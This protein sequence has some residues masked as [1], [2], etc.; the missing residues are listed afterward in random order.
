MKKSL[1]NLKNLF[2]ANFIAI[3]LLTLFIGNESALGQAVDPGRG[4]YV[5][6]FFAL[7]PTTSLPVDEFS[8]LCS[9]GQVGLN[10]NRE[11]EL[12]TYCKKFHYTYIVLYDL[13]TIFN[14]QNVSINGT[15]L[16]DHLKRFIELGRTSYG[17]VDIGANIGGADNSDDVI[18]YNALR[19]SSSISSIAPYFTNSQSVSSDPVVVG[20]K[21]FI[22]Q[23]LTRNHE[24][25]PV[26]QATKLILQ[27]QAFS[28]PQ[29]QRINFLSIEYE[30]WNPN[31]TSFVYGRFQ[32]ITNRVHD[33]KTIANYTLKSE[34]Y[35]AK[36]I[37][38]NPQGTTVPDIDIANFIDGK[39]ANLVL[40][41]NR[42]ML[43]YYTNTPVGSYNAHNLNRL[44][45]LDASLSTT[46]SATE[47][48]P[49]FSTYLPSGDP[50][51][52]K[53]IN[54]NAK[55]NI[56]LAEREYYEDCYSSVPLSN[57]FYTCHN[58]WYRSLEQAFSTKPPSAT[59][60]NPNT[61]IAKEY[62]LIYVD[63]PI[64][65]FNTG[66]KP[67]FTYSG[68]CESGIMV[69]AYAVHTDGTVKNIYGSVS[70]FIPT[71][72]LTNAN[73]Y[74][75]LPDFIPAINMDVGEYTIHAELSYDGGATIA[76]TAPL[77][78]LQIVNSVNALIPQLTN[79]I[80]VTEFC[81]GAP[82]IFRAPN[83][84][85]N[86]YLNGSLV[87]SAQREFATT[88]SASA[89][90]GSSQSLTYSFTTSTNATCPAGTSLGLNLTVFKNPAIPSISTI[91][92]N[93]NC[94]NTAELGFAAG[95]NGCTYTWST[96]S[97][98]NSITVSKNQLYRVLQVTAEGCRRL[99][100]ERATFNYGCDN[101]DLNLCTTTI[102]PTSPTIQNFTGSTIS[103]QS[104]YTF[105]ILPSATTVLTGVTISGALN[106][107]LIV[108]NGSILKLYGCTL[109]SCGNSW[110]GIY[111]KRWWKN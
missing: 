58:M 34:I 42:I 72:N 12:L 76:Y 74:K 111:G 69:R 62:D 80:G 41:Y 16:I 79:V 2:I 1:T 96:G 99:D 66:A 18:F 39:D 90:G 30:F 6:N 15:L 91:S 51:F 75:A 67:V 3:F 56:F 9:G 25:F 13:G 45:L 87:A 100:S 97:I 83:S 29:N 23:P 20:L 22:E 71:V 7:N 38:A 86:W 81:E 77:K 21:S 46:N 109:S 19:S 17:I 88:A 27:I 89:T 43:T 24:D 59:I 4:L 92:N 52:G 11:I 102:F 64:C 32:Q 33:V 44:G 106:T 84:T 40:N 53:W 101:S 48:Y 10:Y 104:N 37:D 78:Y 65:T 63:G 35:L 26:Q 61:S 82:L 5:N 49:L 108:P 31:N 28:V 55:A 107:Q 95:N 60:P 14:N 85:A 73:T 47:I 93:S 105:P 94:D 68:P 98:G 50:N 70:S 8:I 54:E 110:G 103:L 57:V 36:F